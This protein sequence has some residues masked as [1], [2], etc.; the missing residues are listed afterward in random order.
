MWVSDSRDPEQSMTF[1]DRDLDGGQDYVLPSVETTMMFRPCATSTVRMKLQSR[2]SP[3]ARRAGVCGL[4]GRDAWPEWNAK[5]MRA[6]VEYLQNAAAVTESAASR[7]TASVI[8]RADS[9][10]GRR[11]Q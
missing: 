8:A 2:R 7:S 1:D 10:G 5:E 6:A 9:D 4:P 11:Q 3:G